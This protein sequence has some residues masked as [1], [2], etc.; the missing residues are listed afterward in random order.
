MDFESLIRAEQ[1]GI[2][3][4][5]ARSLS[6]DF[7]AA[8]DLAQEV[9]IRAWRKL[10]R[11]AEPAAQR[12]WLRRA[13]SNAAIDELRR[14]GRQAT[15]GI[16]QSDELAAAGSVE[17]DGAREALAALSPHDRLLILLRFDAGLQHGE[18]AQLLAISEEAARKRVTRARR[19]FIA[20]YRRFR[21]DGP[22][23]I[24]VRSHDE[25][26]DS[27][28]S[29]L[30]EAGARVRLV[31]DVTSERELAMADGLV[32]AGAYD[33][34]HSSLY[35]EAPRTLRGQVDLQRDRADLALIASVLALGIPYVGICRGHQML[36]IAC[37]GNLYQDV[38]L[39]GVADQSHDVDRHP[40]E[41][42]PDSASRSMYGRAVEV[43]SEHHQAVR[44]LGR[45]LRVAAI[46]RDGVVESIEHTG[47]GFVLGVQW[48]PEHAVDR[49]GDR[50]AEGLVQA[51]SRQVA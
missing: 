35:G 8:E 9:M 31:N 29:W 19:A 47:P 25:Y 30:E 26:K 17:L 43:R 41:T 16:D 24:L 45:N 27:Y 48:H 38:L 46:S 32:F 42:A 40:I 22:P 37:G 5:L 36:N 7:G 33:D 12:A 50:I 6:G 51:A 18:I 2:T 20:T 15:V 39:D 1:P 3:R 4:R 23:V 13:A 49:D 34:I 21:A 28:I 44:K 14:R 11:D 10:P